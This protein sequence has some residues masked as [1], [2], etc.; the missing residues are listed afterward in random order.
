MK[1]ALC[2]CACAGVR[3][4]VCPATVRCDL[5]ISL[6]QCSQLTSIKPCRTCWYSSCIGRD[7]RLKL[8]ELSAADPGSFKEGVSSFSLTKAL[9]QFELKTK[10][11]GHQPSQLLLSPLSQQFSFSHIAVIANKTTVIRAFRSDCSIGVSNYLD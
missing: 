1:E 9:A 10:K 6:F 8:R 7:Y 4:C 2:V 11:K 5:Q 3:V